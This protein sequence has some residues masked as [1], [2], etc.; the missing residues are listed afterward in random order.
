MIVGFIAVIILAII[1]VIVAIIAVIVAIVAIVVVIIVVMMKMT[2][3][4]RRTLTA[5]MK[6]CLLFIVDY[7]HNGNVVCCLLFVV[8][9]EL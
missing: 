8:C 4:T 9:F 1:V 6:G 5:A 7:D 2:I 3:I